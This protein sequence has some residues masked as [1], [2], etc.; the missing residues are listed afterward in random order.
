MASEND[1]VTRHVRDDFYSQ[2]FAQMYVGSLLSHLLL[3]C[4]RENPEQLRYYRDRAKNVASALPRRDAILRAKAAEDAARAV[5]SSR[6][7]LLPEHKDK[8]VRNP[9]SVIQS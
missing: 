7:G 8:M 1:R 3:F 4:C 5:A 6:F 2:L 9:T